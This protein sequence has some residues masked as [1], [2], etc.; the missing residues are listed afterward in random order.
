MVTCQCHDHIVNVR[1]GCRSVVVV[2]VHFDPELTLRSLRERLRLIIHTGL[3]ILTPSA[4][5]WV[6]SIF[7]N[8]R[9]EDSMSGIKTSTD[10]DM[11]KAA[12]FNSVFPHVLEIAQPGLY[13]RCQGLIERLSIFLWRK[14]AI[15]IAFLMF[16]TL[17]TRCS[18]TTRGTARPVERD[19]L[20]PY[21]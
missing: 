20:C 4:R 11:E 5:S 6:T 10:S 3:T 8:Q 21:S 9:K 18:S 14:R 13:A 19:Q 15:S 2:N 1:S 17:E 7:A 16:L 12:L